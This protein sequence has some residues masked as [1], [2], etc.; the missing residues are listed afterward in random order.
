M[1]YN[2]SMKNICIVEQLYQKSTQ[3]YTSP[4]HTHDGYELFFVTRGNATLSVRDK[5]YT[6][7]EGDVVFI[8]GNE[9]HR[10]HS[11]SD[12]YERVIIL[13]NAEKADTLLNAKEL[14]S[15]L[16]FRPAEFL[17]VRKLNSMQT[18]TALIDKI[19]KELSLRAPLYEYA[20]NALLEQLLILLFREDEATTLSSP[21]RF[22]EIRKYLEENY[23]TTMALEDVA[24]RFHLSKYY[25]AH[26]FKEECGVSP[27]Q[28]LTSLRLSH[29]KRLLT[30]TNLRIS[31]VAAR[32]GF[33]ELNRFCRLFRQKTGVTPKE[34]RKGQ[35]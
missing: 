1:R 12:R 30:E 11:K 28:Y 16:K 20:V 32:V 3:E 25:L 24:Q 23:A 15:L 31:E 27:M 5:H 26:A 6:V 21:A 7:N 22:A 14:V 17:H 33:T 9:E 10:L 18:A 35:Q 4:T 8:S 34:Y 13:L 19:Q 2:E 29:A